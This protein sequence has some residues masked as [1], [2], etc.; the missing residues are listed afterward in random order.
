MRFAIFGD[1]HANLHALQTVLA[2]A[3]S[4]NCTH[5]VCMGDVV[6]YN[7][8][9]HECLQIVRELD[10]P[11][12]KGN[13][14]EQ[15]SMFGDQEGFNPLAEEAMNWTRDQLSESEKEW[16]RALR[17]QRQVRD[18]TIVHATLDTPHRWGYVFNQLDAAASFSYQ[19]TGICFIGHTHAPKAYIRDGSV[20]T[21]ALDT[22]VL[23]PGKKYLINVGSVGQ[24]RDGDPRAAY[25]IY[26]TAANEVILRRL[27][28]DLPAAQRAI[29]DAGLPSRLAERLAVGR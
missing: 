23:Q 13:H 7:A 19:H 29:L 15:A 10:C 16:L 8:F 1:I 2:D 18:F 22:L 3:Q 11:V 21:I 12:V 25:C 14:D 28:Y 27:D 24:P 17:L 9:P 6:G 5:F 4:Q 20:R 26:D